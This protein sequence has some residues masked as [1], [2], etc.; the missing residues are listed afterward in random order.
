MQSFFNL[1]HSAAPSV[2]FDPT[3]DYECSLTPT[4]MQAFED[5]TDVVCEML[6]TALH[7]YTAEHPTREAIVVNA[8]RCFLY[9]VEKM[10]AEDSADA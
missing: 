10:A 7:A 5:E 9:C 6:F 1:T 8:A 3:M 4:E 2:P